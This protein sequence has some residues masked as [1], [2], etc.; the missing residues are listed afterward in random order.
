[1]KYVLFIPVVC[2]FLQISGS[3]ALASDGNDLSGDCDKAIH[4]FWK[5]R[6][7]PDK[8][9]ARQYYQEAIELCS[10]YIRPYELVGN[11]YRKENQNDTAITYFIK[12]AELGTRNHMILRAK[13][14][15]CLP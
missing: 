8:D 6:L 5:G 9:Q 14:M 2:F 3:H 11:L 10:G 12:A 15:P 1:M 13:S 4:V 7:A